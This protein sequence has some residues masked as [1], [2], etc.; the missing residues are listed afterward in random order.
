MI[1][2]HNLEQGSPEWLAFRKKHLGASC[3]PIILGVSPFMTPFQLWQEMLSIIPPKPITSYMQRGL[4]LEDEA[5]QSFENETGI[6]VFPKVVKHSTIDFLSASL[7]GIDIECKNVVEIKCPGKDAHALAIEGK[8][9]DYYYPQLQHQLAVT[10]LESIFYFSYD[11]TYGKTIE[12]ARNQE[13]I[14][15]L[16]ECE[17]EFWNYLQN[18]EPPPLS[19]KDYIFREDDSWVNTANDW[20]EA[21][22]KLSQAQK[23]ERRL[24][25]TLID[26]SENHSCFGGGVKLSKI[27]RLG[28]IDYQKI[29]ELLGINLNPYRKDP[30][31]SWRIGKSKAF[32][33]HVEFGGL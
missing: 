8:V 6:I 23:E 22:E 16:I 33:D 1:I 13:Y 26:L 25:N 10:G 11:G 14:N 20:I 3:A 7:D 19:E 21:N 29:P 2:I 9:P 31:Q 12:V 4:D 32:P 24:K 28:S 17:E 27:S 5:R 30:T 18:Q 15:F